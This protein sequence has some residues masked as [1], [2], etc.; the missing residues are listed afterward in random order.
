MLKIFESD[1]LKIE[2]IKKVISHQQA[3]SQ[4]HT[5]IDNHNLSVQDYPNTAMAAKYLSE[6]DDDTI[7]VIASAEVADTYKDNVKFLKE[8][9]QNYKSLQFLRLMN[10]GLDIAIRNCQK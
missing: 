8:S 7:G 2:N 9:L 1:T 6:T 5:F 10:H 4:C 3:L